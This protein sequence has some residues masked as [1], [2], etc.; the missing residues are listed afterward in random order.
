M[1]L[2]SPCWVIL[3]CCWFVAYPIDTDQAMA[4]QRFRF[5]T[6]VAKR[7]VAIG[8]IVVFWSFRSFLNK[9]FSWNFSA[10]SVCCR[11]HLVVVATC[12][13]LPVQG[14]RKDVWKGSSI[15][16]PSH[17]LAHNDCNHGWHKH[18]KCNQ[19]DGLIS[20]H[21]NDNDTRFAPVIV[22]LYGQ[23]FKIYWVLISEEKPWN[24]LWF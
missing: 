4:D 11:G 3:S 13:M 20:I 21:P 22:Q 15:R 18:C 23:L 19:S 6:Y 5:E 9:L 17:G 7:N 8:N 10:D 12:N 14:I 24:Y 1:L 16:R 2:T